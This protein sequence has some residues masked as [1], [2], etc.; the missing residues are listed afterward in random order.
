MRRR[1]RTAGW[2]MLYVL[3]PLMGGLLLLEHRMPLSP[4]GHPYAQ[5]GIVLLIYALVWLWANGRALRHDEHCRR[6]RERADL[7]HSVGLRSIEAR[8]IPHYA[9]V[10]DSRARHTRGR[11]KA[12]THAWEIRKCSHSSGQPSPRWRSWR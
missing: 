8:L 2:W 4:R 3:V 7:A 9:D 12:K 6:S 10:H 1:H 5:V 11:R